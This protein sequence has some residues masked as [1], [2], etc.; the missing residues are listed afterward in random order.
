MDP[1]NGLLQT[2]P[3]EKVRIKQDHLFAF[4]CHYCEASGGRPPTFREMAASTGIR[5]TSMI[6]FYLKGLEKRGLVERHSSLG[7]SP[8]ARI[9][10]VRKGTWHPPAGFCP[11]NS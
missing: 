5:S 8:A 2:Y 10:R 3:S 1:H 6:A 7:Q 9:W 11:R 4:I